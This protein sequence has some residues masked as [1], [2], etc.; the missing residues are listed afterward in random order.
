MSSAGLS[1]VSGEYEDAG[2]G[3]TRLAR[4]LVQL[5]GM[6]SIEPDASFPV[7]SG[8]DAGLEA[9]YRFLNNGKVKPSAIL[10]PHARATV[11]RVMERGEI[12][13]AHDTTEF[14]FGTSGRGDLGRVGQG[15]SHG[16]YGHFAL[17][18]DHAN[19][20]PLGILSVLVHERRGGKGRRGHTALQMVDDNESKRWP[21]SVRHVE[22]QLG[23]GKCIHVMDREGDSYALLAELANT[24]TRFV[25]RMA[26]AKRRVTGEST[27][28]ETLMGAPVVAQREVPITMRGRSSMPSYRKHF[29]ERNA[30]RARLEITAASVTVLRPDSSNR[31]ATKTLTLNAIRVWEPCPPAGEAPVEWRLWTNEPV[32]SPEQVLAVVDA[33]RGRWVIEEYFKALKSGC[34]I[35]KRQL[36][37]SAGLQNTLAVFIPIAW[38]LLQLRTLSRDAAATPAGGLLSP[39]QLVCLQLAL[40]KR[41][42]PLLPETPTARDVMLGIAGLGGHIKNNGDPGWIV[43]GRGLDRLLLLEEGY[44]LAAG[45]EI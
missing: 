35:E 25:V 41:G 19:R 38:R 34:A 1:D 24:G 11:R 17:A 12:V 21:E 22:R 16:F 7:A 9:T 32:A 5:A 3:D 39:V 29:P 28:G 14:N 15:Q 20:Q 18:V 31:S 27:V 2:F 37:S 23:V 33:Y 4:R 36:E 13:V 43:L 26:S 42:R 6:L 8:G 44:R 10:A 40:G 30:R 45:A